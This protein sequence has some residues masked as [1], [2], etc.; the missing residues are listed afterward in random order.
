[1]DKSMLKVLFDNKRAF[2]KL[3][4]SI[5]IIKFVGKITNSCNEGERDFQK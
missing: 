1:M 2:R 3:K 5:N 4:S